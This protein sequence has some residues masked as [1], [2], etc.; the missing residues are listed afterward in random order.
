MSTQPGSP[1]PEQLSTLA[2][3][4]AAIEQQ[5]AD[6]RAQIREYELARE[7][8]LKLQNIR[9]K[10]ESIAHDILDI[11]REQADVRAQFVA[12]QLETQK[13]DASQRERQDSLIIHVFQGAAGFLI[14]GL[15]SFLV[16]YFTHF[17]H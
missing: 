11:R 5:L 17:I 14:L 6:L 3:R 1:I 2:Y 8:E 15:I 13:R 12:Q 4:I 9:D 10:M 16:N 7:S